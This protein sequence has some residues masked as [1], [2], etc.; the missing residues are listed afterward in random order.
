V[1]VSTAD[2]GQTIENSCSRSRR[3]LD[4]SAGPW[5]VYR[6]EGISGAA[7]R[8]KQHGL[9]DLL[10]DVARRDFDIVAAWNLIGD[11]GSERPKEKT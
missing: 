1:R 10:K 3:P 8:A 9:D 5:W 2:R 4:G 6:D 7:G 11:T